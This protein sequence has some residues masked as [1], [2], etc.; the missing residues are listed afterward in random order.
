[1]KKLLFVMLMVAGMGSAFAEFLGNVGLTSD[2]R[3]RGISQTMNSQALQGGIDYADKSGFYAG[4]WNSTVSSR[5]YTDRKSTR[6]NSS[7]T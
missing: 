6:L 1:M 2:Y 3:F 4:N 5:L 7:H